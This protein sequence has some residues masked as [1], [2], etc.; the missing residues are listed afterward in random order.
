MSEL[1]E[2]PYSASAQT[3]FKKTY[4]S[5]LDGLD[6]K[7]L[8]G[9]LLEVGYGTGYLKDY[10][11]EKGI[12]YRGVDGNSNAFNFARSMYGSE[13][14]EL[15]IFPQEVHF[16]ED[17]K[18]QTI[19]SF[20]CLDEVEDKEG[21]LLSVKKRLQ[22][23]GSLIVAVRNGAFPINYLKAHSSD[24]SV[25]QYR[26][27]FEKCGFREFQAT[28]FPRP[29]RNGLKLSILKNNLYQVMSSYLPLNRKYMVLFVLGIKH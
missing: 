4:Y 11:L 29:V 24:I 27:T 2:Y 6:S 20:T 5:L 16:C 1:D 21:F 15:G 26:Q 25:S 18:F 17:D 28:G 13:F 22:P 14:F 8:G 9:P 12:A 3:I 7:Y 10:F 19:L 23:G